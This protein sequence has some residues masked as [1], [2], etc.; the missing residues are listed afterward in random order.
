M[1][2]RFAIPVFL[3]VLGTMDLLCASEITGSVVITRRLSR[4]KVTA[5]ASAYSR[6]AAVAFQRVT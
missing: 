3:F 2:K 6:G 4:K 5:P 1:A